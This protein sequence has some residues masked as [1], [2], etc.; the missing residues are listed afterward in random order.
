[1]QIWSRY[2]LWFETKKL[3]TQCILLGVYSVILIIFGILVSLLIATE[4]VECLYDD[5]FFSYCRTLFYQKIQRFPE[6]YA[7]NLRG[8][9]F[10]GYISLGAFLLTLKTFIIIAMK[11]YVY[12][13]DKYVER[14][15]R[16]HKCKDG[17][18][19]VSIYAPLMQL[20]NMLYYGII[21]SIITAV[22]QVSI[23]LIDSVLGTV[24][25]VWL[26]AFSTLLLFNCLRL[27]KQNIDF[28]LDSY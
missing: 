2:C 18:K 13:D 9:F 4:E 15:K 3:F 21:F 24:F 6:Y 27:I 14:F 20:S 10:A 26:V 8:H 5:D 16:K 28:W 22:A 1:M 12:D 11:S 19:P 23:G 17:E 7:A 25:C